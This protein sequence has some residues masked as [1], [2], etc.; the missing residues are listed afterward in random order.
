M[1]E[2]YSLLSVG[3][4][5][6]A[7]VCL[8]FCSAIRSQFACGTDSGLVQR[9]WQQN[10]LER[11]LCIECGETSGDHSTQNFSRNSMRRLSCRTHCRNLTRQLRFIR[12]RSS[13]KLATRK[14]AESQ[15]AIKRKCVPI[16]CDGMAVVRERQKGSGKTKEERQK[17]DKRK[18]KAAMCES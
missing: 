18:T 2:S 3:L 1:D 15:I 8:R 16:P 12:Q 7:S 14:I 17:E 5:G 4:L 9:T 6:A 11:Q 10:E 13:G